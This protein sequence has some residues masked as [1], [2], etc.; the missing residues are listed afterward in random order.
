MPDEILSGVEEQEVPAAGGQEE[1]QDL[2]NTA[3]PGEEEEEEEVAA[4]P[5]EEE[6]VGDDRVEKAFA[7]R[8]EKERE[9]LRKEISADLRK[10]MQP[11]A[12]PQQRQQQ[13]YTPLAKQEAERLA[14]EFN[15]SVEMVYALYNQQ[16]TLNQYNE[17]LHK[18]NEQV[19]K[20]SDN[21]TK[22]EAFRMIEGM[23]KNTPGLPEVN[24]DKLARIRQDYTSKYGYQLPW[25]E[26][27]EKLI[28]QE[29]LSGNLKREAEQATIAKIT[30]R[31]KATI[32]AGKGGQAKKPSI[33]DLSPD[34]F[35][36]LVEE[37][38]MGKYKRT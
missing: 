36:K 31:N 2:F 8:L 23:R 9:K 17:M 26:A 29:A 11:A 15:T 12:Q 19:N 27:Y 13:P 25:E 34:D 20:L 32:Q 28:A 22:A 33:E 6:K 30:Q 16:V 37:A 14:D 3:E 4:E 10:E 24:E 35:N 5:G 21:L 18:Q 1:E 7:K 38:K